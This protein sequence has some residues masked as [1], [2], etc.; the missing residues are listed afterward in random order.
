MEAKAQEKAIAKLQAMMSGGSN[1]RTQGSIVTF[2]SHSKMF[3]KQM[4]GPTPTAEDAEKWLVSRR[5]KWKSKNYQNIAYWAIKRLYKA[6]KWPFPESMEA[7]P[8]APEMYEQKQL[9]MSVEDITTLVKWAAASGSPEEQA[10][11]AV[12]TT[13]GLRRVEM[14]SIQPED[15]RNDTLLIR[16]GKHGRVRGHAIPPEI[17]PYL[18]AYDWS[19]RLSVTH[20]SILFDIVCYKAGIK[21]PDGLSWH[22]IRRTLAG[23]L[24]PHIGGVN[25][26]SYMRWSGGRTN[27][28]MRYV[29]ASRQDREIDLQAFA[30][31]PWLKYWKKEE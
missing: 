23:V 5:K 12:A 30:A 3:L 10:M 27:I 24:E 7:S 6:N 18:D 4:G 21:K 20:L 31:I 19:Q 22:G 15:F 14:Q 13:Y 25:V 17:K 29:L 9:P 8:R 11:I 28:M 16:T 26:Q 2:I 1:P